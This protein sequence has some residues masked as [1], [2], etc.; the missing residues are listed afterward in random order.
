MT[1]FFSSRV[2]P[3]GEA[4]DR[5]M[6][7]VKISSRLVGSTFP[8][9]IIA[10]IGINHNG[11][12]ERAKALV[13][14]AAAAG[15]DAVKFQKRRL[16]DLYTQEVLENP[17]RFEEGL[18]Y[19]IPILQESEFEREEYDELVRY[20]RS[21][22]MEFL[23]TAFD[24]A[25][26][27]FL[28]PYHLPAHKV[29]SADF[30]NFILLQKL[31]EKK[32]PLL[33]S[34]GMATQEE[35][36]QVVPFLLKRNVQYAL[37][38][39][40]SAYPTPPEDVHL[41]FIQT[42]RERY[43]VPV[44][45]S[46]HEIGFE[47]TLAAVAAGAC[48]VERHVTL[49]RQMEGPDH[50]SSLEPEELKELVR[51]IRLIDRAMGSSSKMMSRGVIRTREILSKSLVATR[52]IQPGTTIQ[53]EM[54]TAKAPGKGLS[55][56]YLYELLGR[57]VRRHM[58]EDEY[59]KLEDLEDSET[60]RQ[61]PS[62][63]TRWGLKGRFHELD[64]Y[65]KLYPKLVEIH[66][67]D[68]DIEYPLEQ[69]HRGKHYPFALYLH[70]PTYWFR[71]V[72]NLASEDEIERGEHVR[73]VQQVIDLGRRLTPFFETTPTVIVH[74]GGMDIVKVR[75]VARIKELTYQSMKKLRWEGVR[76]LPENM[77]PR[78]WYF[79]GQW[80]D[81]VFCS[82]EDMKEVCGAFGLQMC[83]DLSHAKLYTNDSGTDYWEYL[84]QLAPLT[85]HLHVADAYGLDGE[86][87]QIGEGEIDFP[88][89]FS[90]LE[91]YGDLKTMSWTPE[92]WQGH[93]HQ[94][95]GFLIALERLAAIP[96]LKPIWP[97]RPSANGIDLKS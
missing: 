11:S 76:F 75:E 48:L 70:C 1:D 87:V 92:I 71:S 45:Y 10:E 54:V 2:D 20:S 32:K 30:T 52:N 7:A 35:I 27:D 74:L 25:S 49:D 46:G 19:F 95:K 4:L 50:S 8:T 43:G 26:I 47:I 9:Y 14:A 28:D 79:S 62:F 15:C 38:H 53:R 63:E 5:K 94:N 83:L 68:R 80:F 81:N 65:L 16:R 22:G 85:A 96:Q 77:P 42:M 72:L 73:V 33:L 90:I 91:A 41:H 21:R 97:S 39:C 82:A 86:G 60:L 29:A 13:D 84:K 69:V 36:D 58:Q 12:L 93:L 17:N 89:A 44:G 18:Q 67:N 23:C 64:S 88:K 59:F 24:E 3:L 6:L 55:P 61:V 78:P 31:A 37:L 40:I 34:T 57:R 56:L 66:L 51:R